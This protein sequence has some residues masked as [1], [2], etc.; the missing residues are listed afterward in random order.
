[1][2]IIGGTARINIGGTMR[3]YG[4]MGIIGGTMHIYETMNIFGIT[5]S[6]I[7]GTKIFVYG[8]MSSR[9]GTMRIM[10]FK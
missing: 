3:I 5:L 7:S 10:L 4:T 9:H 2:S 1:M 8:T 6:I